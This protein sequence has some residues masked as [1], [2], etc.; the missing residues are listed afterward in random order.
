M[1]AAASLKL[2]SKSKEQ[3]ELKL[4]LKHLGTTLFMT[5]TQ[6]LEMIEGNR[7]FDAGKFKAAKKIYLD[8][9][10]KN[11]SSIRILT[12][13]GFTC[14]KM[15]D[16]EEASEVFYRAVKLSPKL[17]GVSKGLF[18]SLWDLGKKVEALEEIKRFQ[19]ISHSDDYQKILKALTKQDACLSKDV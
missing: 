18:Y 9:V 2:Q 14:I 17:Q 8:L 16:F 4:E 10:V 15:G 7:L 5:K 1:V 6:E 3:I 19:S 11:S 12:G 13:L